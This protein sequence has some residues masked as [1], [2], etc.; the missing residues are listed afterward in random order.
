M[1]SLPSPP[2]V[3]RL[4][5]PEYVG[6]NRCLPCTVVNLGLAAGM[7]VIAWLVIPAAGAAIAVLSVATIYLRGYLVPGTPTL[8]KRYLPEVVLRRFDKQ[9]GSGDPPGTVDVESVLS[10]AGVLVDGDVDLELAPAFRTRWYDR[11]AEEPSTR[12]DIDR[13][14]ELLDVPVE[15]F[16]IQEFD[17]AFVVRTNGVRIAQW[18]S[19][20][21]FIADVAAAD[22]LGDIYPR[23]DGFSVGQRTEVLGALRL[24]LDECPD[25]GG[26]VEMGTEVQES[27]CRS[28]DVVTTTCQGCGARLFETPYEPE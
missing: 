23:W 8:T 10:E 13:L 17:D 28:Y 12:S 14:R 21:A 25:C 24:F 7:T 15:E 20:P 16:E 18:E 9:P 4:R 3:T 11:M 19:H 6:E 26:R 5:K 22:E 1:P 2:P 27:C